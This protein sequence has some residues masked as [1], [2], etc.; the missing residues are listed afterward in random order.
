MVGEGG[1]GGIGEVVDVEELLRLGDAPGGEGGGF[2]LLIHHVIGVEIGVL[3]LLVVYLDHHLLFEPGY[4]HLGHVVELGGLLPLAGDNEGGPGFVDEDGVHLVHDG[5]GVAPLHQLLGV[6]A[7]IVPQVVEAHL[8]VGAVSDVGGVGLLALLAGQAVNDQA[9]LQSQ[10]AVDLAH[11]LAVALGQV[12]VDG[13]N[14]DALSRQSVE[15]GGESGH[16]G[17]ALTGLHLGDPALVQDDA[18][19]QLHPVGA[20]A[21]YPVGGFPGGGKGLRQDVIQCLAVL[22]AL[23]KLWCF[24]LELGVGHCPILVGHGFDLIHN[25]I[26]G[27]QLPGAVISK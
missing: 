25:G 17:L 27:F 4:Q 12:V 23:F 7:H 21:Q 26:D 20:H 5:E 1:V 2:G 9:H 8:V 16:Q 13:D 15:I 11:P 24:G 18:A 6:D 19:Y 3:L 10:E 22:Q 14:V